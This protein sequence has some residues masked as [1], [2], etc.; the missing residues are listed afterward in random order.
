M[1]SPFV[2]TEER[3]NHKT[4]TA[5]MERRGFLHYPGEFYP[6]DK[7]VSSVDAQDDRPFSIPFVMIQINTKA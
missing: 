7:C 3:V 4:I 6:Y 1:D 2:S 5:M